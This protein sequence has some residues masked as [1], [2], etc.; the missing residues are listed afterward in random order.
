MTTNKHDVIAF[1]TAHNYFRL[2]TPEKRQER[3]NEL[4][5]GFLGSEGYPLD[6]D[7][8]ALLE[9]YKARKE[10]DKIEKSKN[11]IKK[12]ESLPVAA[13]F[14]NAYAHV[15]RLAPGK[16]VLTSSQN[17]THV[18]QNMLESLLRYCEHNNARLLIGRLT[19]NQ[20]GFC[21]PDLNNEGVWY[22]NAVK[23]YLVSGQ[24]DLGGFC[25]FIADANV[26]PTAKI[27]ISGGFESSTPPGIHAIIPATKLAM[28]MC[29]VLKDESEKMVIS[30][31]TV[32]LRN[33]IMRKAGALASNDHNISAIFVDTEKG[34]MRQLEQMPGFIGF[35]DKLSRYTPDGV[36]TDLENSVAAFQPGDIH[37]EKME[38]EN[39]AR[40]CELLE[41]Y[42]PEHLLIHDLQDFSS[43]NHHS[44]KRCEFIHLQHVNKVTIKQEIKTVSDV[45]TQL[46][47]YAPNV[48]IVESNH[49][50][51]IMTYLSQSDFKNDPVNACVYLECMLALY[52]HQEKTGNDEFNMLEYVYHKYGGR[53]RAKNLTFHKIDD[54]LIIAGTQM[55]CHGHLGISGARGNPNSYRQLGYPV[56]VG[57]GHTS[58]IYGRV[59]AAGVAAGKQLGYNK[60]LSTWSLS[61]ILTY[62]NGQRQIIFN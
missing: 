57:H 2:K 49:D 56:N 55:A 59:Y 27:P 34:E 51:A 50:L 53:K 46:A 24:L 31:G 39:L 13:G 41:Y 30:T 44:I 47:K 33:Y 20:T 16:Y 10:F 37:A 1:F 29:P 18:D 61:H 45:V 52:K 17:N 5:T 7:F 22:D 25:H 48:H 6:D 11:R 40:L 54:S 36:Q 43:R 42:K 38:P 58:C 28:K 4:K 21:Q 23:P 26:I 35:Y 32:T 19:Y 3:F 14:E 62:V 12:L 60:G 9:K 15:V 8:F